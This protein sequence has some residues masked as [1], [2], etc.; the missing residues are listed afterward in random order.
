MLTVSL[1]VEMLRTKPRLV[2]WLAVL[3]QAVLWTLVPALFYA[4]PPGDVTDVIAIGKDFPLGSELGPPLAYWIAEIAFR[5]GGL[6]A[7]YL[8]SQICVAITFFSV[9][10][11]G[12][13]VVGGPHAALAVLLMAGITAFSI[14]TPDFGPAILAMPLWAMA[15]LHFWRA[16]ALDQRAYWYALAADIGLLL[17]TTYI[18]LV[19]LALIIGFVLIS[20]RGSDLLHIMEPWIAGL[21]TVLMLFP[22]LVWIDQG[23][24][25]IFPKFAEVFTLPALGTNAVAGLRLLAV[26][27]VS[28]AG[29]A[30]LAGIASN[31]TR[32]RRAQP[33]VIAR[34]PVNP[35]ARHYVYFFALAPACAVFVLGIVFGQPAPAAGAPLI[36][37]SG[38]ALVMAAGDHLTLYHQRIAGIAWAALL[39]VP[40]LLAA[41]A[42]VAMPW[43]LAIDMRI[44]QPSREMTRFLT[45]SFE[46][47]TGKPLAVVAGEIR[48]ASQVALLAPS[49][50]SVFIDD[51]P[52]H[53][54][55]RKDIA[56]KGAI[57]VWQATDAAGTPPRAVR[58]LFP[59]LV[60]ELPRAFERPVQGRLPLFRIGWGMIRPQNP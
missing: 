29:M 36:V 9:F 60:A 52:G 5:L 6:T 21:L 20:R 3:T 11:L 55:T 24:G 50:P 30:I 48:L 35:L 13:L 40:P 56:E 26:L 46:R 8:L 10:A 37:L 18:G 43:T 19:L 32:V 57:V 59:D 42:V 12:R 4:S 53:K 45:D 33:L 25:R 54:V 34:E 22:H 47:R 15:L 39:L 31:M 41:T 51:R 38:L 23:G 2:V 7:V 17:L 1:F 27:I 16:L 44:A 58:E 49:R 14:P 28:H